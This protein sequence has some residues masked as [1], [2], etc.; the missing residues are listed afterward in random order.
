[1]AGSAQACTPAYHSLT[2]GIALKL[3]EWEYAKTQMAVRMAAKKMGKRSKKSKALNNKVENVYIQN[4]G[5][6]SEVM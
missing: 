1:M 3:T 2:Q 4:W 5:K 6:S